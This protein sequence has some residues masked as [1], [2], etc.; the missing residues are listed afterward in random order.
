MVAEQTS[1]AVLHMIC[2]RRHLHAGQPV[3]RLKLFVVAID[4][5]REFV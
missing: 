5:P 3:L 1:V 2:A 4:I